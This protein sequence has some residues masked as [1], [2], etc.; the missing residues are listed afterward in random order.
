MRG[1]PFL[2]HLI[3]GRGVPIAW[4][5][6]VA[7]DCN[8]KVWLAGPICTMGGGTS[9]TDVTWTLMITI[10]ETRLTLSGLSF[11]LGALFLKKIITI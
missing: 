4:Q 5:G 1:E 10:M 9:S 7:T 3:F 2:Y 8:G 11:I 6:R